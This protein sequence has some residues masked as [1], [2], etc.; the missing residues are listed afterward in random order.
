MQQNFIQ[1]VNDSIN[2][3]MSRSIIT[4]VT[5]LMVSIILCVFGGTAIR[6]FSFALLLGLLIGTYSSI[7]VASPIMVDLMNRKKKA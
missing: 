1:N 7:F 5:V 2:Q 4:H 6:G 3:T